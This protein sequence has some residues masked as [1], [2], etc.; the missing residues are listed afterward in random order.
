MVST[1]SLSVNGTA[2]TTSVYPV[3]KPC[4]SMENHAPDGFYIRYQYALT[5]FCICSFNY[6]CICP[7]IHVYIYAQFYICACLLMPL[8]ALLYDHIII[9]AALYMHAFTCFI[10]VLDI[11]A[12]MATNIQN[13]KQDLTVCYDMRMTRIIRKNP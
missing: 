7:Y 12:C 8:C 2:P 13:L 6:F 10:I 9:P 3:K 1:V 11:K 4:S 5:S